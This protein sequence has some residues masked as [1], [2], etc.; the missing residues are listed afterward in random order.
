MKKIIPILCMALS[1]MPLFAK[2]DSFIARYVNIVNKE[3]PGL[4][5]LVTLSQVYRS[6]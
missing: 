5:E 6:A 2:N 3:N 1:A 4:M